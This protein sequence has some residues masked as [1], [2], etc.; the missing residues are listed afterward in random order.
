[1]LT[2]NEVSE[3]AKKIDAEDKVIELYNKIMKDRDLSKEHY[4]FSDVT[5]LELASTLHAA[6]GC[7][8]ILKFELCGD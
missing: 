6:W 1:M 7:I 8:D 3:M 2:Q 5:A 4:V